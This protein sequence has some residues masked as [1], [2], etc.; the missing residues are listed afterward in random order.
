MFQKFE[1]MSQ[2]SE[3]IIHH[4]DCLILTLFD[5]L[6]YICFLL[7]VSQNFFARL[8]HDSRFKFFTTIM[9]SSWNF[10][11]QWKCFQRYIWHTSRYKFTTNVTQSRPNQN[12]TWCLPRG[13]SPSAGLYFPNTLLCF[14]VILKI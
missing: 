11:F 5:Q 3:S 6:N 9:F 8:F 7:V 12:I 13:S 1:F 10:F 4:F 2:T 14:S